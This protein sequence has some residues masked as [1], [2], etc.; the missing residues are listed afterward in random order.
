MCILL[1]FEHYRHLARAWVGYYYLWAY[2]SSLGK[3]LSPDFWRCDWLKPSRKRMCSTHSRKA[4]LSQGM[5]CKILDKKF[6]IQIW[7]YL[8]IF[9][10]FFERIGP[11]SLLLRLSIS[12]EFYLLKSSPISWQRFQHGPSWSLRHAVY[13][14]FTWRIHQCQ[15]I[16][17][18]RF[19]IQYFA[20]PK[21]RSVVEATR[22]LLW[23]LAI[24]WSKISLKERE[25]RCHHTQPSHQRQGC[26]GKLQVT[27]S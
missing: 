11:Y 24:V 25:P 16:A 13:R 26:R 20:R 2:I 1:N 10:P 21:R 7:I 19:V 18:A 4:L 27:E 5:F 23:G 3:S 22:T 17:A 9:R 6:D 12:L 15:R 14:A 8:L